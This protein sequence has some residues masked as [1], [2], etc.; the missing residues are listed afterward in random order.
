MQKVTKKSRLH[1]ISPVI[2]T[3]SMTGMRATPADCFCMSRTHAPSLENLRI[4]HEAGSPPPLSGKCY[5][6]C[7]IIEF[8][9]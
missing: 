1:E 5:A 2:S 3:G 4:F 7:N 8:A 6:A 9:I